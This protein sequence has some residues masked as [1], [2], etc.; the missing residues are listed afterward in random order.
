MSSTA[1]Q[2]FAQSVQGILSKREG[3]GNDSVFNILT[4]VR[5]NFDVNGRIECS[6]GIDHFEL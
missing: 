3:F 1:L 2:S 5:K 6:I 4:W